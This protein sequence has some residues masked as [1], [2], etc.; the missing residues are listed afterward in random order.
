MKDMERY[1]SDY[2]SAAGF[3]RHAVRY[4]RRQVLACLAHV[5]HADVLEVGCGMEPLFEYLDGWER[6]TVVEPGSTF[7]ANARQR[8]PSGKHVTVVE[9]YLEELS[10]SL[11]G[12]HFD[13]IVASSL[14]HEVPEPRQLLLSIRA[15]CGAGTSVHL[16]VPNAASLHNRLAV[17][18]G[19][20]PDLFARSALADRMQRRTTYDLGRL[21]EA[22]RDAGFE[23]TDQ[24]SYFLKPFTH[25]QLQRMLD[26]GIID[27]RVLDALF[28][29][30]EEFEGLGAEI[31]VNARIA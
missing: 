10:P 29:V 31:F 6:Y 19:L 21:T 17:R 25:G 15:L 23:V 18:M 28:D 11:A 8:A 9:G 13:V 5:P 12:K 14:L 22:V 16:N 4:R 20:I 24:G 26:H 27:E 2:I 7:A 3:E 30:N 1:Q